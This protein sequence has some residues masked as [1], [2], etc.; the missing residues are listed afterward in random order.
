MANSITLSQSLVDDIAQKLTDGTATAEQVVLY[1]KGLNQLQTGN[2]FQSVVIG[3]SQAAVDT[4]DSANAQFQEDAQT[5][6]NTF[7]Q[8]AD[9]I[10]ASATNAVS[11]INVAKDVLVAT[12][13]EISTT[14]SGLPSLTLIRENIQGDRDYI[15]PYERPCFWS[16]SGI[17]QANYEA[18]ITWYNHYGKQVKNPDWGKSQMIMHL[19][20]EG[21]D[22][23]NNFIKDGN[24][25]HYT[26]YNGGAITPFQAYRTSNSQTGYELGF[27]MSKNVYGHVMGTWNDKTGVWNG[28]NGTWSADWMRDTGIIVG[29]ADKSWYIARTNTTFYL[30]GTRGIT[31]YNNSYNN[32]AQLRDNVTQLSAVYR[33]YEDRQ[34]ENTSERFILP[35][36]ISTGYGNFCYNKNTNQMVVMVYNAAAGK[37]RPVLYS[38]SND[39]NLKDIAKGT[40]AITY[41][42]DPIAN[43]KMTQVIDSTVDNSDGMPATPNLSES[44]YRGTPILCDNGKVVH[45]M[46]MGNSISGSSYAFR[47]AQ[48]G[49]GTDYV[50]DAHFTF[51]G[52][53]TKYGYDQGAYY[54]V[55]HT[56]TNDGR[57][58]ISYDVYYYYHGGARVILT[59]V[60]DGKVLKWT[61]NETTWGWSYTPVQRNKLIVKLEPHHPYSNIYLHDL[62][63]MFDNFADGADVNLRGGD[64]HAKRWMM[65]IGNI[66]PYTGFCSMNIDYSHEMDYISP[67]DNHTDIR[68]IS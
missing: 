29:D 22:T 23:S 45:F 57:Y 9:N 1:T 28:Y 37:Q 20:N 49:D 31:D 50:K 14:I 13:A 2:D 17:N 4:I 16:A 25:E 62:D 44:S 59:R 64:S 34:W 18:I 15:H 7:S 32:R 66:Q 65:D 54:G 46:S 21:Y 8:T 53:T 19:N 6:L 30:G 67:T 47:W 52:Q 56:T 55:R 58:V 33:K 5:A 39:W 38:F 36:P 43:G 41:N 26:R 48:N 61:D 27:A 10:D 40:T 3:L 63:W 42:Y 51:G 24:G 60:S 12:D 11:A 35:A 68:T